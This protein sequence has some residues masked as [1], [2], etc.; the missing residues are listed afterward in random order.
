MTVRKD[1]AEEGREGEKVKKNMQR[2]GD[3]KEYARTKK[4]KIRDDIL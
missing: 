1:Q 2:N 3:E 4:S